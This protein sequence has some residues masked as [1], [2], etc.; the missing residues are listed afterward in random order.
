MVSP[1]PKTKNQVCHREAPG[2]VRT[3]E[4]CRRSN[5]TKAGPG[6]KSTLFGSHYERWA[7][8]GERGLEGLSSRFGRLVGSGQ[9]D[10]RFPLLNPAHNCTKRKF[11]KEFF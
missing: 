7:Y 9:L 5:Q 2:P 10:Q 3:A 8:L 11:W 6:S 4:L 1:E